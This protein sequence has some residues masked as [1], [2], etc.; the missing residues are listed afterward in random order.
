M[1][2]IK[3][4]QSYIKEAALQTIGYV[5]KPIEIRFNIEALEDHVLSKRMWRHGYDTTKNSS[6]FNTYT[7]KITKEDITKAIEMSIEELTI[8]TMQSRFSIY[9]KGGGFSRFII[10]NLDNG[11][12]V[13]CELEPDDDYFHLVVIT[14]MLKDEFTG[15]NGQFVIDVSSDGVTSGNWTSQTKKVE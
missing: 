3:N 9:K 8:S 15:F 1:N 7:P 10:R 2:I 6:G 12:N 11:L 14:V 4:F 5:E 13:V